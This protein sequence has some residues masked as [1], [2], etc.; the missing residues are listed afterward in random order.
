[1]LS[2]FEDLSCARVEVRAQPFDKRPVADTGAAY[3]VGGLATELQMRVLLVPN[4]THVCCGT[5]M[6]VQNT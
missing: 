5:A 1:M 3:A 6:K 2:I 4:L